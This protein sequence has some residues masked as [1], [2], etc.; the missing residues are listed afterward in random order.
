MSINIVRR[1]FGAIPSPVDVRDY[2]FSKKAKSIASQMHFPENFHLTLRHVKDQGSVA[3]CVA[4]AIA[5]SIEYFNYTQVEDD[6]EMSVGYIYGNR[7]NSQY[8][9]TGMCPRDALENA[10]KYGD[11]KKLDFYDNAEIPDIIKTFEKKFPVLQDKG[12]PYAI[13]SYIRI[14]KESEI[15]KALMENGPVIVSMRWYKDF[16][17]D[18]NNTL[19]SQFNE[20]DGCGYHCM[21]IFGW[22]KNGWKILNSWGKDFGY[23]GTFTYPYNYPVCELWSVM[24]TNTDNS[25]IV[26]PMSGKFWKWL[27]K[28][29]NTI[30]NWIIHKK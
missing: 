2:R 28:I 29:I 21:V 3:S 13:T 11:V 26:K 4:H 1:K 12:K 6:E 8:F 22:N 30:I 24:D 9:G 20:S 16:T 25:D 5:E 27:V 7:M 23:N 14:N 17:L 15:K 19:H 10:V 18:I